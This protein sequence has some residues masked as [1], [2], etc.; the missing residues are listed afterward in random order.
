MTTCRQVG[1]ENGQM[2]KN[3]KR[4][5]TNRFSVLA[6]SYA[7]VML[8]E[9]A[10]TNY[11]VYYYALIISAFFVICLCYRISDWLVTGYSVI[12]LINMVFYWFTLT[13]RY[14]VSQYLLYDSPLAIDKI[15]AAYEI[16]MIMVMGFGCGLYAAQRCFDYFSIN[17]GRGG[18]AA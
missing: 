14:N 7:S 9:Y 16:L 8:A 18:F 6:A 11:F 17:R 4:K 10:I 15:T 12:Q 1:K 13:P 2:I 3:L 5:N